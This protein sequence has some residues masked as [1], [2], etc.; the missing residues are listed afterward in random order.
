[1]LLAFSFC[2]DLADTWSFFYPSHLYLYGKP[3]YR[4]VISEQWAVFLSAVAVGKLSAPMGGL[5]SSSLPCKGNGADGSPCS[6]GLTGCV[7]G[8]C[9]QMV[10]T[11]L[12]RRNKST[13]WIYL[14]KLS[15]VIKPRKCFRRVEAIKL[16]V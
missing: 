4:P 13:S 11:A 9:K 10:T 7:F 14:A 15:S 1:M 8:K 12:L 2:S 5:L 6:L 16:L 3:L